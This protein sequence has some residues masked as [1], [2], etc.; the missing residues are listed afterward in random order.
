MGTAAKTVMERCELLGGLSED[1]DGIFRPYGSGSMR[2]VNRLVSGWMRSAG[3]SVRTDAVGNLI[4]RYEGEAPET[5]VLGSHLDT[6]RDAGKY[7]GVLGVMIAL[8]CVEQL[9]ER[10]LPFS[11]EVVAFCDEEGVRFGTTYLGS[12]AFSGRF[13][14]RLL[15]FGDEAGI[16]LREAVRDFGG[17]PGTLV[18]AAPRRNLLGYC[19]V[20]I[21]QGPVL[22]HKNL[23]VGVVA[24]IQ[25][26]SRVRVSFTGGAG[27]AGTVPMQ[28]RRDALCAASEFVLE[29]ERAA[30]PGPDVVATVGELRVLPGASNVIPSSVVLSLDLRHP[31]DATRKR[32]RDALEERARGISTARGLGL[33]WEV[34]QESAAVPMHRGLSG[35]LRRAVEST[36]VSPLELPSGAGHDAAGMAAVAAAAML[37]VRC[38]GGVSHNPAESVEEADVAV[39][40]E[41]VGEFLRRLAE[42]RA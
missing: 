12:S 3:L 8:S 16:S 17:E 18:G 5:L 25:G 32:L 11:V 19:E 27:H 14:G 15:D 22:E 34:R 37:F 6:V 39:A 1:P 20:H 4:G 31:E 28:N 42:E 29:V 35:T 26:Q 33:G 9:G 38:R 21:E 30:K 10:R 2:E 23:P 41:V 24:G 13:D 40:V 36:G 7:D